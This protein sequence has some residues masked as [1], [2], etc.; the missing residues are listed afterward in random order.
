V[1]SVALAAKS[2]STPG[3]RPVSTKKSAH[4]QQELSLFRSCMTDVSVAE[5]RCCKF[6]SVPCVVL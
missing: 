3:D 4:K 2:S 1:F 6:A 5:V